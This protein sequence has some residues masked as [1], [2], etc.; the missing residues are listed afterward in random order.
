MES[1]KK[2]NITLTL[3]DPEN[4]EK[5]QIVETICFEGSPVYRALVEENRPLYETQ[6]INGIK[7]TYV[8]R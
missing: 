5:P 4:F 1:K 8:K 3:I 6:L 7:L 2:Q